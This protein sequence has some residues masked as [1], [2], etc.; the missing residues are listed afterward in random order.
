[1]VV[2]DNGLNGVRS[3]MHPA[4]DVIAEKGLVHGQVILS[5]GGLYQPAV[6]AV[7][8]VESGKAPDL[9]CLVILS[10]R[11]FF[12]V[13]E[14]LDVIFGVKESEDAAAGQR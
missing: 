9:S 6:E 7:G 3:F 13:T 5:V 1:M 4:V 2:L 8:K 11:T 12:A 14:H 10:Q